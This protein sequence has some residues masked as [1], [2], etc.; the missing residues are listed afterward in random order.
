MINFILLVS[1]VAMLFSAHL[2]HKILSRARVMSKQPTY[3]KT[4]NRAILDVG[5][6]TEH[7]MVLDASGQHVKA[8]SKKSRTYYESFI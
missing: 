5:I 6:Y 8:E 4:V 3:S 2:I 7:G 1:G